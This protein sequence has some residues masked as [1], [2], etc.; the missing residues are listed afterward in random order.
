MN[1]NPI[2]NV[3]Q[4]TMEE[5]KNI[6][7]TNTIVGTPIVVS[8]NTTI[9]PVSKINIG[10]A[11]GGS[12]FP[13]KKE[14]DTFG[15]GG[16]AGVNITPIA[17]LVIQDGNVRMLQISKTSNAVDRAVSLMPEMIDKVTSLISKTEENTNVD[18]KEEET[19]KIVEV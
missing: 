12:E 16:G 5:V 7:D 6:V 4:S 13:T 14:K 3:I 17:F 2:K 10:F 9:I 18:K 15:G 1:G 19:I 11:S 8:E